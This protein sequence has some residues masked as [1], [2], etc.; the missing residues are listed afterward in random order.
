[1]FSEKIIK[2]RS[3]F[4]RCVTDKGTNRRRGKNTTFFFRRRRR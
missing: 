2:T 3:E 4:L 1:M